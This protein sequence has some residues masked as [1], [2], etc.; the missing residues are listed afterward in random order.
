LSTWWWASYQRPTP[1]TTELRR[2]LLENAAAIDTGL[3]LLRSWMPPEPP[4]PG[5][6]YAVFYTKLAKI[7]EASCSGLRI[8]GTL[9]GHFDER[10]PGFSY[11]FDAKHRMLHA[12]ERSSA[13]LRTPL[14]LGV[15]VPS[16][17]SDE[18]RLESKMYTHEAD[19]WEVF[20]MRALLIAVA[21]RRDPVIQDLWAEMGR[22][23]WD[24]VLDRLAGKSSTNEAPPESE[25]LFS[26]VPRAARRAHR[27]M[28]EA[29]LR[30]G[31]RR[32]AR[33]STR[34][35]DRSGGAL[36]G[37]QLPQSRARHG[38]RDRQR[39]RARSP[40]REAPPLRHRQRPRCQA[41][42]RSTPSHCRRRDDDAARAAS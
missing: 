35:R 41:E 17:L 28:E 19:A 16:D 1:E 20:A 27:E 25:W 3:A 42:H 10:H 4:E 34:A 38:H 5:T 31:A 30:G 7:Y 13:T 32:R 29:A 24:Y 12:T 6:A 21:E 22:P 11:G 40:P 9:P 18:V 14:R 23:V 15:K 39:S 8:R 33:D 26:L 37:I 2:H 36:H